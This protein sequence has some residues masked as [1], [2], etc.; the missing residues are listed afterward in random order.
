MVLV[1]AATVL[2]FILTLAFRVGFSRSSARSVSLLYDEVTLRTSR[3]PMSFFDVTPVGRIVTRFSSDYGNVFRIFGGPISE[4][5]ALIY[6]IVAILLLV[7]LTAP[8]FLPLFGGVALL[9]YALFCLNR[10]TLRKNRREMSYHRGPSISHFSETTQGAGSVRVYSRLKSFAERFKTLDQLYN[11]QKGRTISLVLRF[12][13]QMASAASLL[14]L[15]T[16]M[17]GL[18][19]VKQGV[20]SVGSVGVALTFVVLVGQSLQWLFE[21]V[22]QMEEAMTGVERLDQYLRSPIE[23]GSVLPATA[24]IKTGHPVQA[25]DV[26]KDKTFSPSGIEAPVAV[27]VPKESSS[28]LVRDLSLKYSG[29]G[30]TI[31]KNISFEIRPGEHVGLVGRTGSGKSSLVQAIYYLYPFLSGDISIDSQVPDVECLKGRVDHSHFS[32]IQLDDYRAQLSWVTQEPI[33]FRG[34]L[35][36]NLDMTQRHADARL[37]EVLRQVGL[38]TWFKN[39]GFGFDMEIE[40]RG[41]NVSQGEKQLI[42]MARVI[43]QNAPVVILDEAT[44][45]MDPLTESLLIDATLHH[46]QKKTQ[47]IIAHRL[48]TL[49]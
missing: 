20:T 30:A 21:W 5:I 32:K 44:S 15:C 41:R 19:L 18:W 36:E 29:Q 22:M 31:L 6:D 27:P 48:S 46:F 39:Q 38:E 45:F 9:N 10:D 1:I 17:F 28:I 34:T 7:A 13:L 43:L 33:L 49:E 11:S 37:Y 35:R 24:N 12:S 4:F 16:G 2:G 42:C 47:L 26:S 8:L 23:S 25:A 40:E 3:M 14:L